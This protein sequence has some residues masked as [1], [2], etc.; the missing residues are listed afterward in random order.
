MDC[1]IQAN[2]NKVVI[3]AAMLL[4]HINASMVYI[5]LTVLS[6]HS[7]SLTLES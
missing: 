3:C 6:Y 5:R 7:T 1:S 2:M 4:K